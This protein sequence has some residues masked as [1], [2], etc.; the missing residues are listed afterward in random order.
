M[1][2]QQTAA[3][4]AH[5][6]QPDKRRAILTGALTVFARDG[7]TRASV[8]AIAAEAGVSTRT[9]Y[10]HFGGKATVF[11]TLIEESATRV[12]EA[13]IAIIDRHLRKVTDLEADLIEFGEAW[14]K[15]ANDHAEHFALV[16]QINAETGHIP[17][18]AITTWQQA[19]PLRVRHELARHLQRLADRRLLRV[20]DAD[21]AALHL[22]ALISVASPSLTAI[23]P[24]AEE[25]TPAVTAGVHAFL[26]GYLP[27]PAGSAVGPA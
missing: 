3:A 13:Q 18:D 7:Y 6:G 10:N 14:A 15:A 24:T 22:T 26:H 12:A 23:A 2:G 5:R 21:R 16:R 19:G 11:H 20:A 8:D 9:I 4:P 1:T 27:A 25:I 17:Q